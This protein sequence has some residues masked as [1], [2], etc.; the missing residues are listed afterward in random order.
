MADKNPFELLRDYN[1]EDE[2]D[3]KAVTADEEEEVSPV[4]AGK[5]RYCEPFLRGF[6][7]NSTACDRE[8]PVYRDVIEREL[9]KLDK[10]QEWCPKAIWL[11]R[12]KNERH[13]IKPCFHRHPVDFHEGLMI[14]QAL[15]EER[16]R[17]VGSCRFAM[18]AFVGKGPEC[19]N[20]KTPWKCGRGA[21]PQTP[22]Q[23]ERWRAEYVDNQRKTVQCRFQLSKEGCQF[24]DDCN[25]K[26]IGK[27]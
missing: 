11:G 9:R 16:Y 21:H 23:H 4:S 27:E 8:H 6:C 19:K 20:R 1:D 15:S 5:G 13:R 22:G 7:P 18:L 14:A 2:V 12:C 25:Y 10:Q 26:H 3:M 17:E 24:G